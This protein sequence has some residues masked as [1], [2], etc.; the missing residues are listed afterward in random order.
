MFFFENIKKKVI[1]RNY[2]KMTFFTKINE[3]FKTVE[4]KKE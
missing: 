2:S 1:N 3:I 4:N